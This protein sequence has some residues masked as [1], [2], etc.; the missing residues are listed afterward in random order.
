MMRHE[1]EREKAL[2][3]EYENEGCSQERKQEI[4]R[5]L[6]EIDEKERGIFD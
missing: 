2:W 4:M 1:T 6:K 5:E 3:K